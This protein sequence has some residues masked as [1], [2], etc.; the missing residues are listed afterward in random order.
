[1]V[2]VI[3]DDD[4]LNDNIIMMRYISA[5]DQSY[6]SL[7]HSLTSKEVWA[8]LTATARNTS[9]FTTT[10]DYRQM[11]MMKRRIDDG[12][13]MMGKLRIDN[14]DDEEEEEEDR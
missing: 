1:M 8:A 14:D 4:Q 7:S 2:M 9:G 13:M 6:D 3:D 12:E 11:M 5:G 10:A